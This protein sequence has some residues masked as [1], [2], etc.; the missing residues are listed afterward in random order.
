M[1]TRVKICGITRSED[2]S[3]AVRLGADAIGLVF[4]P[5]SPRAVGIEQARA[6][7]SGLPPFV[8][9]VGLFVDATREVIHEVLDE[10]RIDLLQ[11][12]GNEPPAACVGHGKPYIKALHMREDA[13]PADLATRYASSS[14]LL[15]DTYRP[16]LVGG[17]GEAFDW[18]RLPR[19]FR[20]PIILAGGL[21]PANVAAAVRQV[22]PY[23]VDVSGGVE[24]AKGIKDP[25][26]I[27]AFIQEVRNADHG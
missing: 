6:V 21:T 26:K 3:A 25:G 10:V 11:F 19:E 5:P 7:V 24:R 27:A 8:T 12:H 16:G 22:R 2:A 1:R 23:A 17:T 13:D 15:L 18:S 14:G 20:Q 4:Y 9:V